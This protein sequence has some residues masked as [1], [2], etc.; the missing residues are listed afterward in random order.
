MS[1]ERF[2]VDENLPAEVVSILREQGF[3]VHSVYDEG[4]AGTDD[5]TLF[6]VATQ[7]GRVLLTQ[8][9]DFADIRA[10]P[11]GAGAGVV[12]FR[13]H[14]QT[15]EFIVSH[16]RSLATYLRR[17]RVNGDLWILDGQKLRI[18]GVPPDDGES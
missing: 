10:F 7:E 18:R 12:V 2:K 9:L 15:T 17:F 6:G 14:D 11:P 3:D 1:S 5:A 4:L 16:T 13:S 8:D